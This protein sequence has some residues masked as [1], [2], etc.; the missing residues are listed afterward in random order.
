MRASMRF[1]SRP[2]ISRKSSL[3]SKK[4]LPLARAW[5]VPVFVSL[6][7]WPPDPGS[8]A[9]RLVDRGAAVLGVNCCGAAAALAFAEVVGST[10]QAPL[11]VKPGANSGPEQ[12]MSPDELAAAVPALLAR[13]VR[14]IGG[15]CGTSEQHVA[16]VAA[17]LP[18]HGVSFRY[19]R[20]DLT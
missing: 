18:I 12:A 11:L 4:W 7:E 20:G 9:T 8:A 6:W 16:A 3:C 10:V 15:C 13:N 14:L 19:P 17:A 2:S 5:A 1:C